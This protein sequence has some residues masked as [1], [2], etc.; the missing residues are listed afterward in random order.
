MYVSIAA[1]ASSPFWPR[2][3]I[4]RRGVAGISA[5]SSPG[6]AAVSPCVRRCGLAPWLRAAS[7]A[8][9]FGGPSSSA[10]TSTVIAPTLTLA[11]P[12][13]SGGSSTTPSAFRRCTKTRAPVASAIVSGAGFTG[14]GRRASAS[15]ATRS[16]SARPASAARAPRTCCASRTICASAARVSAT[17][18]STASRAFSPI[19]RSRR[20]SAAAASRCASVAAAAAASASASVSVCLINSASRACNRAITDSRPTL[21]EPASV[22]ARSS[23]ASGRPM[24]AAMSNAYDRPGAPV[25]SRNVGRSASRS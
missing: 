24:R 11:R 18:A 16:T 10:V 1:S 17:A 2:T 12:R 6:G 8:V 5:R 19:S 13:P 22:R 3:S 9:V 21:D 7:R 23:S 25:A 15:A 4:V 20:A 14:W